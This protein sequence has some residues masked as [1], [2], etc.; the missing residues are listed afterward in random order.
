M[1]PCLP[2]RTASERVSVLTAQTTEIQQHA[3][4]SSRM[5]HWLQL[6]AP[7]LAKADQDSEDVMEAE[8]LVARALDHGFKTSK[9]GSCHGNKDM[10]ARWV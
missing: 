10:Q 4:G 5:K 2:V 8:A 3:H 9:P 1:A 6:R 7:S